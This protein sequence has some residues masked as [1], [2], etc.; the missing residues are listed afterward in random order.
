MRADRLFAAVGCASF[1]MVAGLT[2]T[3][4]I[5]GQATGTDLLWNGVSALFVVAWAIGRGF[6]D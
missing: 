4:L 1:G 6:W 2:G 3:I 5:R